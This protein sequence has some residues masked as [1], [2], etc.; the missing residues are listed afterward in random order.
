MLLR[1]VDVC[2]QLLDD[3]GFGGVLFALCTERKRDTCQSIPLCFLDQFQESFLKGKLAQKGGHF[4]VVCSDPF[5]RLRTGYFPVVYTSSA[6]E[7]CTDR[8]ILRHCVCVY[9]CMYLCMYA[10]ADIY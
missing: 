1:K 7:T 8:R 4:A 5:L 3:D 10:Y 2:T 6:S 9:A